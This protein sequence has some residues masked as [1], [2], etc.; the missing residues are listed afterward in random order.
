MNTSVKRTARLEIIEEPELHAIHNESIGEP[1]RPEIT[2]RELGECR[3]TAELKN[4]HYGKFNGIEAALVIIQVSFISGSRI[5]YQ[6][7]TI[8]V[9]F[10]RHL[11]NSSSK[12]G[13]SP[14]VCCFFP[15]RVFGVVTEETHRWAW[16]ASFGLSAP[17]TV[18]IGV[19]A[20]VARSHDT[21]FV[22]GKRME[23]QGSKDTSSSTGRGYN[24]AEWRLKENAAQQDGIPHQFIC[25]AIVQHGGNKFQADVDIQVVTSS[26]K[27]YNPVANTRAWIMQ[28]WPWTKDD[29]IN[30]DLTSVP[31]G[32]ALPNLD[33]RDLGT[34]TEEDYRSLAR[35]VDEYQV[36]YYIID[37]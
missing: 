22:Q 5:R 4:V 29:P 35:L 18:P 21:E 14:I 24:V 16:N 20:Q 27:W 7:A 32:L 12:H 15:W 28:A 26:R 23:I 36:N 9:A 17:A 11:Y 8:R 34:L 30:F 33:N 10:E 6:S 1:Y 3:L 13:N 19:S 37:S 31:I 2:R 25:A